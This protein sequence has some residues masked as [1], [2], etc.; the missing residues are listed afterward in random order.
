MPDPT[1]N[2]PKIDFSKLEQYSKESEWRMRN[3]DGVEYGPYSW[4]QVLQFAK[5]GRVLLTSEFLSLS[6]TKGKWIR[7]EKIKVVAA[8]IAENN[9]KTAFF[10]QAPFSP[11][12]PRMPTSP[13]KSQPLPNESIL[14][15]A[16]NRANRKPSPRNADSNSFFD[17]FDWS[18]DEYVTP[19]AIRFLWFVFVMFWCIGLVLGIAFNVFVIATGTWV[20]LSGDTP[21]RAAIT[22]V[23]GVIFLLLII[24]GHFLWLLFMRVFYECIIVLFDISN[25]LKR[26]ASRDILGTVGSGL[27]QS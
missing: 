2:K 14:F 27:P 20:Q 6:V 11:P 18:F 19:W 13:T 26:V 4:E 21:E 24:I 12:T 25:S 23:F 3:Q 5:E 1:P 8:I 22:S 16:I 7:A 17:V 15:D 10:E 9:P